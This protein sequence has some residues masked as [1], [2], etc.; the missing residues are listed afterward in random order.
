MEA[1]G[2]RLALGHFQGGFLEEK[3]V[4]KNQVGAGEDNRHRRCGFESVGVHALRHHALQR[5]AGPS[6]VLHN[7]GDGRHGGHHVE[8]AG[9]RLGSALELALRLA[10]RRR[11]RRRLRQPNRAL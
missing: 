11:T 6:D 9:C 10:D 2:F 4:E 8:R 7:T 5:D 1:P 3:A